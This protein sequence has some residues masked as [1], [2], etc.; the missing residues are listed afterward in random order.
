MS[1]WSETVSRQRNLEI[2]NA[3]LRILVRDL[4]LSDLEYALVYYEDTDAPIG[5]AIKWAAGDKRSRAIE[6][7]IEVGE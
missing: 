7:G 2:E 3:S 6:L 4:F 5:D 1:E